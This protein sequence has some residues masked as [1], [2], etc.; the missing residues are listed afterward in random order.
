MFEWQFAYAFLLLPL[1]WL[2]YRFAPHGTKPETSLEAPF[3]PTLQSIARRHESLSS[4]T[5]HWPSLALLISIWILLLCSVARPTWFGAPTEVPYSSRD[6]MLA[7]D[8]SGSMDEM[9]MRLDG[10]R[11]TRL[12]AVKQI[13]GKFIERRDSDRIGLILF[14]DTAYLQ[15]PFTYDR[16]A[17][18]QLLSEA[19]LGFAG[20]KTAIGDAIGLGIK[21][22]IQTHSEHR[23]LILLTDGANS[24]GNVS[25][26]EA[27]T[28]AGEHGITIHT[29]AIGGKQNSSASMIDQFFG[30]SS[31][32][33]H[34]TLQAIANS[35]GGEYF[36]ASDSDE[37][38]RIYATLDEIEMTEQQDRMFRPSKS[39][40][41][42]PLAGAVLLSCLL[43]LSHYA[44]SMLNSSRR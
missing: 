16:H 35:T 1:P 15:S 22:M 19:Q 31:Q 38:E 6:L 44:P 36:L 5:R 25:P 4:T 13:L 37:L 42:Y 10:R 28:L 34:E 27:A 40:Y 33:D 12:Q 9:D 11:V 26:I 20:R 32:V 43:L 8:I 21:Q 39:L 2:V 30:R 18:S 17:V 29:I 41:H 14:A 23:V 24:A 7:V 3:L